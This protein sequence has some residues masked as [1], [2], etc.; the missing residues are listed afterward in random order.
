MDAADFGDHLSRTSIVSTDDL[1]RI[2]ADSV[3]V[4]GARNQILPVG[5]PDI[6]QRRDIPRIF[7]YIF[8]KEP[9]VIN[10]PLFV[11]DGLRNAVALFNPKAQKAL[12]TL[13]T[14]LDNEFFCTP[15]EISNLELIFNMKMESL[16]SFLRRY[17]NGDS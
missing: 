16:E 3:S 14:L 9:I 5:G 2:A 6:L 4:E 8:N 11:F 10:P 12:G 7:G 17:L 15:N 13:R 1:A